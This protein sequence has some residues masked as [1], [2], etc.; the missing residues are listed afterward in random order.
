MTVRNLVAKSFARSIPK[1]K[2]VVALATASPAAFILTIL[3]VQF[4]KLVSKR[5][6]KEM[7]SPGLVLKPSPH[8][9]LGFSQHQPDAI[10]HVPLRPSRTFWYTPLPFAGC[11][12]GQR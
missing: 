9:R 2:V 5:F 7:V 8:G 4:E 11:S 12:P 10:H 6:E 1:A 3:D